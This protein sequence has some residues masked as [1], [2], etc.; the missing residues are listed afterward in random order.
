MF[1]FI[2]VAIDAVGLGRLSLLTV[3]FFS[4]FFLFLLFYRLLFL[5]VTLAFLVALGGMRSVDHA[6][7]TLSNQ[8]RLGSG[9]VDR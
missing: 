8:L 7:S 4:F 6:M 9:G 3:F 1:G 2:Y 5:L